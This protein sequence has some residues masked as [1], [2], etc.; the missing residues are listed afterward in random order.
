MNFLEACN[1]IRRRMGFIF[2]WSK[3]DIYWFIEKEVRE[4]QELFD[5]LAKL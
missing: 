5:A 3:A 4:N 2:P 1:E